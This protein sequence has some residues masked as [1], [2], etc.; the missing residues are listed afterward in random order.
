K[1]CNAIDL[2]LRRA[3]RILGHFYFDSDDSTRPI[4]NT[5][6]SDACSVRGHRQGPESKVCTYSIP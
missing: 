3:Q 6:H 2:A 5:E 1:R 4:E